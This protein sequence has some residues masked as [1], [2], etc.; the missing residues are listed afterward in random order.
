MKTCITSTL[1][2]GFRPPEISVH[3]PSYVPAPVLARLA[4][5]SVKY[6]RFAAVY[7]CI[8]FDRHCW[9]GVSGDGD[10]ASYE[11]FIFRNGALT[12]SKDGY[13]STEVALRDALS[14]VLE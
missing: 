9:V 2:E 7:H 8:Q 1:A 3:L 11:Y 5:E 6:T 14:E 4:Q 10:N 12:V 13:G